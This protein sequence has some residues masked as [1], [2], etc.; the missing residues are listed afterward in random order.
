MLVRGDFRS[1]GSV[2]FSEVSKRSW[3]W[4]KSF[5][6]YARLMFE[7]LIV[8]LRQASGRPVRSFEYFLVRLGRVTF[9]SPDPVR[10]RARVMRPFIH[11]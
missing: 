5:S 4:I 11:F 9:A 3:L 6:R 1:E 8:D 7:N 2:R 10:F